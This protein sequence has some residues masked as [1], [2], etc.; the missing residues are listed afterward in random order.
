MNFSLWR[1]S[2]PAADRSGSEILRDRLEPVDRA[3]PG[4]RHGADDVV[5]AVVQMFVDQ[6]PP[7]V[8]DRRLDGAEPLRD[9]EART[10][11]LDRLDHA[12]EA[13]GRALQPLDGLGVD[14]VA[15]RACRRRIPSPGRGCAQARPAVSGMGRA[16]PAERHGCAEGAVTAPRGA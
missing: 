7:S 11:G 10:A 1:G 9:V 3:A 4:A 5:E 15:M 2:G 12:L 6:R 13:P 8:G 16:A 14:P